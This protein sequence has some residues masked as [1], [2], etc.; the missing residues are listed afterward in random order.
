MKIE[1]DNREL[2]GAK[3]SSLKVSDEVSDKVFGE[4]RC[5]RGLR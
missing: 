1:M 2:K 3:D 5:Q 4:E